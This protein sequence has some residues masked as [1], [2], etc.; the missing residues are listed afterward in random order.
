MA[1]KLYE[2]TSVQ[3][4]ADA[5]RAKGGTGTMTIAQMADK[6]TNLPS[7]DPNVFHLSKDLSFASKRTSTFALITSTELGAFWKANMSD[8]QYVLIRLFCED[9]S[10]TTHRVLASVLWYPPTPT[11]NG[12]TTIYPGLSQYFTSDTGTSVTTT[13]NTG[14]YTASAVR[15]IYQTTSGFSIY[16]STSYYLLG[17]YHLEALFII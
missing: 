7:G 6:I 13:A 1:N 15:K 3:A 8:Y 17:N 2:E 12:G 9:T 16:L 11:P 10:V 5:I 14:S 4:I